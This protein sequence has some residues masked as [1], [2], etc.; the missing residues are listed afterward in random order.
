MADERS[1]YAKVGRVIRKIRKKM[2]PL[3]VSSK[4]LETIEMSQGKVGVA[5]RK[6]GD[7]P[8]NQGFCSFFFK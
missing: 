1:L 7:H 4:S 6:Q 2:H 5:N 3:F 8:Q